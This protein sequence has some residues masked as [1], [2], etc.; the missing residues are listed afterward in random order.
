MAEQTM[1]AEAERRWPTEVDVETARAR[2]CFVEG[3]AW[4]ASRPNSPA[5]GLS[6]LRKE[7]E[8]LRDI[9]VAQ[10]VSDNPW[11][12]RKECAACV[13]YWPCETR[14]WA[15][16][17]LDAADLASGSPTPPDGWFALGSHVGYDGLL[18]FSTDLDDGGMPLWERHVPAAGPVTR[19]RVESRARDKADAAIVERFGGVP[20]SDVSWGIVRGP[21]IDSLTADLVALGVP[22]VAGASDR[23]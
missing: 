17:I 14:T 6:A 16:A 20:Y 4:Q 22:V 2:R 9:H 15:S 10:D 8:K 21:W 19:E 11:N 5:A 18:E 13:H 12:T 7:I 3:A 23:G 1:T